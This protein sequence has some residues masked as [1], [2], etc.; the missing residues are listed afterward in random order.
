MPMRCAQGHVIE[1]KPLPPG[2]IRQTIMCWACVAGVAPAAPLAAK[3]TA[4]LSGRNRS[5]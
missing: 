1:L 4:G 3:K 2:R 5:K